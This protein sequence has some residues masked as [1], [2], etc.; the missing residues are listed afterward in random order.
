MKRRVGIA[1]LAAL[2][3]IVA[4]SASAQTIERQ[5]LR[6]VPDQNMNTFGVSA[7]VAIPGDVRSPTG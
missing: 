7:G 4:T 1:V 5:P 6:P 2:A 3:A